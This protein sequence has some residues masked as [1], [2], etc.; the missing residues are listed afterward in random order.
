MH[1]RSPAAAAPIRPPAWELPYAAGA[2]LKSKKKDSD[3]EEACVLCYL[4]RVGWG[5]GTEDQN[6]ARVQ[7]PST[8][9][10][11]GA[12]NPGETTACRAS[13]LL[14]PPAGL[15]QDQGGHLRD[16]R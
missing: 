1:V 11:L 6:V 4:C 8:V 12:Q 14:L 3:P 5:W 15:G 10:A 2:A 16:E 13:C 9:Q 7:L